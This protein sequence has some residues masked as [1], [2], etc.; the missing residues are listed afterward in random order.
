MKPELRSHVEASNEIIAAHA[1]IEESFSL[2]P[3]PIH[4]EEAIARVGD[5]PLPGGDGLVLG[6]ILRGLPE[7]A[8]RDPFRAARA[9]D[10]R[11]L[12]IAKAL[13]QVEAA[14]RAEE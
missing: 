10:D 13:A 8:F 4:K 6:D 2:L 12:A 11:M 3:F 9:T 7:K 1:I 5:R 14:E